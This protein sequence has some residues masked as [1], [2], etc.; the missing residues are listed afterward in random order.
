MAIDR[1]LIY[2]GLTKTFIIDEFMK[3]SSKQKPLLEDHF[4]DYL[5]QIIIHKL[6][7]H[8]FTVLF[9]TYKPI[10]FHYDQY[11]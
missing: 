5:G 11:H 7:L 8:R 9:C 4:Y 6:L 10:T 3:Q 1:Q 2:R